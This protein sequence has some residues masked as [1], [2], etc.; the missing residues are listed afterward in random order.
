MVTI[1]ILPDDMAVLAM[2]VGATLPAHPA[3]ARARMRY[4]GASELTLSNEFAPRVQAILDDP[5]WKSRASQATLRKYAADAR[6][7]KETGGIN[8]NLGFM[9]PS[10]RD[11]QHRLASSAMIA[12]QNRAL[13]FHWK[14]NDRF[15]PLTAAQVMALSTSM[16]MH[17]QKC[18]RTE[19]EILT[20]IDNGQIY[21][22]DQVD[23]AFQR[24]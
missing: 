24:V 7:R 20:Q 11:T 10:D 23:L 21:S 8:S 17:V 14:L 5:D 12:A 6:W 4:D 1:T 15:V 18:F 16:H 9:M 3:E 2:V 19:A 22:M 13:M